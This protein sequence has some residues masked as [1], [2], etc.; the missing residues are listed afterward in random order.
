VVQ[1]PSAAPVDSL[2][3]GLADEPSA[4]PRS[5]EPSIGYI[6]LD[7]SQAFVRVIS[8]GIRAAALDAGIKLVECDSGWTRPGVKTC[9]R[10]LAEAGVHGIVSMQPFSD[11]AAE[12]CTLTGDVPT[13]GVVY[14]QGPCEVGLLQVDQTESGRLAGVAMGEFAAK[15]WDC[16]VKAYISLESGADDAIGGAR[17]D[18]YRKGYREH[19]DLPRQVRS[20]ADAQHLITAQTQLGAV[21][22]EIK[23]KP[24]L[25]AGVSDIAV[26]GAMKAAEHR[27]RETQLWY[28]GQLAVPAIRQTI[29][30]DNHYIASVAQFPQRFGKA[31]VPALVE[32]IEGREVPS[33]LDAELQ[34][35]T[36]ANVRQLFPDT[37]ACDE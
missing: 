11:I 20:L 25:V 36:S 17:M 2:E 1:V 21:L 32:A 7:E 22:D 35:V 12:V 37:P 3:P 15:R 24:I 29:A 18:G 19:C 10:Q 33:R 27:D 5:T 28:S 13:I 23:G 6:S 4:P 16:D 9:A 26:L 34:L 14:D 8:D 30:C 31:V